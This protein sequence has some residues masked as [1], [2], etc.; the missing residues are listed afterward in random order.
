MEDKNKDSK[1]IATECAINALKATL[2]EFK[3]HDTYIKDCFRFK[4]SFSKLNPHKII[5][6]WAEKEKH[7]F[8]R[9]Q[10]VGIPLPKVVLLTKHILAMSIIGHDEASVPKLKEIIL[11]SVN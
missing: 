1:A 7:N 8:T 9:M 11:S 3:N 2:S 5:H 10:R 4:D 6:M